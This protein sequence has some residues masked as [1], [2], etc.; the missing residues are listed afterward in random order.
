MIAFIDDHRCVHGV[1]PICRV[2]GIAPSTYHAFKAVERDPGRASDRART[3]SPGHGRDQTGLRWQ[4][5]PIWRTQGLAPAAPRGTRHPPMH[6]GEA[7]ADLGITRRCARQ[8]GHHDQPRYGTTLPGRQ[9]EPSLRGGH[10]EP[11]VG[12]SM[13]A[14][15]VQAQW[16]TTSPMSQAGRGLSTWPSLSTSSPRKIVGWRVSTS[17]TTG[18]VLDALNQAICQ[19]A[20]SEVDKLIHH[21]GRGSQGGLNRSSQHLADGGCDDDRQ[22]KIRAINEAQIT[23]TGAARCG[24]TIGAVPVL[25][26]DCLGSLQRGRCRRVRYLAAGR[27]TVVSR[28]WRHAPF[29][30]GPLRAVAIPAL[31]VPARA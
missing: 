17:M 24:A 8:E 10:A 11:A 12:S 30:S 15:L 29:T 28:G 16:T 9:G 14:P 27:N 21:S 4:S 22:T 3:G 26:A 6:G 20:P 13:Q 1:G 31:P 19:R 5:G 7:D 18:F 23:L 2:L 25:V